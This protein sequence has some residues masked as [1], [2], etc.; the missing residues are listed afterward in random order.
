MNVDIPRVALFLCG[1]AVGIAVYIYAP[2]LGQRAE[3]FTTTIVTVFSILAGIQ[4]AIFALLGGLRPRR[5]RRGTSVAAARN[6]ATM[7]R[8]R[9]L[10]IFYVYFAVMFA[11]VL[12]QAFDL[13]AAAPIVERIY[14]ALSFAA[15]VW[16][17]GLPLA[18]SSIQDDVNVD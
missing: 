11:I 7:K 13:G 18:L 6:V 16:S 2:T 8:V 17:L 14:V 10:F 3:A 9:Q 4:L 12:N 5:F 1:L 15:L